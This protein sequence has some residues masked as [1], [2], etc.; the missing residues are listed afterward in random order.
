MYNVLWFEDEEYKSARFKEKA[1]LKGFKLFPVGVRQKGIDELKLHPD[2]YDAVLLDAEMP[3]RSE[4]EVAGTFG[5]K[6]VI[7]VATELHIPCFVSTGQDYIKKNALFRDIH[8]HVFIKGF[9]DKTAGLGG[10]DELLAAMTEA[11]EQKENSKVKLNYSDVFGALASLGIEDKGNDILLPILCKITNPEAHNDFSPFV[12]YTQLRIFIE[13]IF[14]VFNKAGILPDAFINDGQTIEGR[15][16]VN[17]DLS[18]KY[19]SGK[20]ASYIPYQAKEP[21]F[22]SQIGWN[23]SSIIYF[24]NNNSHSAQLSADDEQRVKDELGTSR[25]K[26]ILYTFTMMLCE[27]I[28]W[29]CEYISEHPSYAQ[30]QAL[31]VHVEPKE[32]VTIEK[33]KVGEVITLQRDTDGNIFYG[34]AVTKYKP[35]ERL[36]DSQLAQL[37]FRITEIKANNTRTKEKYPYFI[38]VAPV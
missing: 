26:Y 25:A 27:A 15:K 2:K 4:N 1:E 35:Y 9:P 20:P 37:S 28:I 33:P 31:W 36:S 38:E 19:L 6:N 13:Y 30:N 17:L 22:P 5:I 34:S 24:A 8:E 10:D 12:H 7:Q 21:I 16:G 23:I 3:E 14:R 29:T 32:E 18:C 11:L